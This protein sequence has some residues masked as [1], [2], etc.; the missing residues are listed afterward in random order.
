MTFYRTYKIGSYQLDVNFKHY[1]KRTY[2]R[3][4][5]T[6]SVDCPEFKTVTHMQRDVFS[7]GL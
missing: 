1:G 3:L 5:H 2:V 6:V 7:V 4:T